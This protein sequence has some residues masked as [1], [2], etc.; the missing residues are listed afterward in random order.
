MK[1]PFEPHNIAVCPTIPSAPASNTPK[2]VI[3]IGSVI[4]N[5]IPKFPA[6]VLENEG[7][8]DVSKAKVGF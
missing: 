1:L 6:V 8:A 4:E 2:L 7:E 5:R 3:S